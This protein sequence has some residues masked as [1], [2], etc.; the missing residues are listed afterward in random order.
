[1]CVELQLQYK[2]AL[3]YIPDCNKPYLLQ[4][5]FFCSDTVCQ[6]LSLIAGS[7]TFK[8]RTMSFACSRR[9][10]QPAC[11]QASSDVMLI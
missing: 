3:I 10:R 2:R 9:V 5:W 4:T 11:T 6:P 7:C 1:M 8:P